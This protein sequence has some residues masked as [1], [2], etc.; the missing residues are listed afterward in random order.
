MAAIKY[1]SITIYLDGRIE[2]FAILA[3]AKRALAANG[4]KREEIDEFI[5]RALGGDY[6]HMLS[7]VRDY[8]NVVEI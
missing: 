6:Y 4:V 7:T 8:V 5:D 1:P 3:K 2:A